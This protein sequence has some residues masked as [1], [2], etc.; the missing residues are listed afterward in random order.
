MIVLEHVSKKYKGI[1]ITKDSG[2]ALWVKNIANLTGNKATEL[3]A[4][5]DVS[6]S[7]DKGEIFGIYGANGAG[8]TTLIKLLSG[9]L[10]ASSGTVQI[11]GQTDNKHIK[12]TV[13][14]ISTNG[15]MGLEWQLTARENLILYGNLFGISGMVLEKKCNEVLEAVGMTAAKDKLVSQ[16]SAGMRQK[17]TIARG[18][19]LDRPIIFYDEPSVSLD[20]QSSRSL[21]ELIKA[22]AVQNNRTAII[23]SHNTEDLTICDRLMLLSKGE[24]IAIGTIDELKKPLADI[25]IIEVKCPAIKREVA[26]EDICGIDSVRCAS[27]DG[28]RG[29][30]SIKINARKG[31]FSLNDLIDFL[32]EKNIAVLDI[33]S[34]EITLQE[35]YEYYL[36]LKGGGVPSEI[37]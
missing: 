1:T 18:L 3:M 26:F 35:I 15:W 19:I 2:I 30:Q 37:V 20:V 21:R 24:I 22:D 34:K 10:G 8:K 13:S 27:V 17:I 36:A 23:A 25:Q 6:F 33:K 29:Y 7:I 14:Y 4:V 5:K 9:L 16:L 12:D 11:D 31:E 28:K 32:I